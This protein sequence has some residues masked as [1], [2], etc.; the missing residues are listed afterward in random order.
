MNKVI[1][2]SLIFT[3]LGMLLISGCTEI[4]KTNDNDITINSFSVTPS[5]IKRNET[6]NLTWNVSNAEAVSI[7]PGVVQVNLT[8]FVFLQPEETTTYT[9]TAIKGLLN[10][11]STTIVPVDQPK[12]NSDSEKNDT[13]DNNN[14]STDN[15]NNGKLENDSG[16]TEG[17][18]AITNTS[19]GNFER[20]Y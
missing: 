14:N 16:V 6:V 11:N 5:N 17:I 10:K 19:K 4:E 15:E 20:Y 7:D 3:T 9:L 1:Q 2:L 18:F 13:K 8:G 12:N